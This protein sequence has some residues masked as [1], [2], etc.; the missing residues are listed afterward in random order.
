L[1]H[2]H[3]EMLRYHFDNFIAKH[4]K[5]YI[6]R[7]SFRDIAKQCYPN[8]NYAKLEKRLFNMYDTDGDGSISF[9]EFMIAIYIMSDGTPEQNL[10]QIFRVFDENND[11][12]ISHKEMKKFV[13]D[14]QSLLTPSDLENISEHNLVKAITKQAF[15][16]M[17]RDNDGRVTEDEFVSATLGHEKVA[18]LLT[19][20]IVNCLVQP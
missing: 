10:R 9:R 5:G 7:K 19:M 11:G 8:K 15:S 16:E 12:A 13:K 17:D 18:T 20:K 4:P 14:I 6:T 3:R 2:C 1:D